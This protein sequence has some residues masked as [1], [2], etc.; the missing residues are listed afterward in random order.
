MK[1]G[2]LITGLLA[3][4]LAALANPITIVSVSGTGNGQEILSSAFGETWTQTGTYT[5]VT[6]TAFLN[7]GVAEP[8]MGIAYLVDQIGPGATSANEVTAPFTVT[9][10]AGS[11]DYV[12]LF[13]N[14][15]LGPGTYDL[16][17][18]G[19]EFAGP[20]GWSN[21]EGPSF[22]LD[23]GVGNIKKLSISGTQAGFAPASTFAESSD[24]LFFTVTGTP[25]VA[26]A[27][28]EPGTLGT[29]GAGLAAL[30][31]TKRRRPAA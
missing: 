5:N 27:T 12:T 2:I 21:T 29:L 1:Y 17:L 8:E 20:T 25:Q 14:L 16:I 30:I 26:A 23:S 11:H 19:S 28:P 15:T 13:S 9:T 18:D 24:A 22:T 10:P 7:G 31:L 4:A 3:Q 6:I